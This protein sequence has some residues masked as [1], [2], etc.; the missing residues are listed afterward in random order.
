MLALA[1]GKLA[2]ATIVS[3]EGRLAVSVPVVDGVADKLAELT[4]T[5]CMPDKE[6][7]AMVGVPL[8]RL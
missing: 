7:D 6:F 1:E 5:T 4:L 8:A 3:V 2:V